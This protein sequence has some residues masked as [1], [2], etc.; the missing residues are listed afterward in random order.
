LWGKEGI[1]PAR[2]ICS[3]TPPSR[4]NIYENIMVNFGCEALTAVSMK[5]TVFW[6]MTP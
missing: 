3:L 2:W 4:R 1:L 5:T 6:Y